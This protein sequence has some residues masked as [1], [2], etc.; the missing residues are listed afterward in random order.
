MEGH[1]LLPLVAGSW[2]IATAAFDHN[3]WLSLL[4]ATRGGEKIEE[5]EKKRKF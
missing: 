3:R 2:L 5:I 4:P 1:Q